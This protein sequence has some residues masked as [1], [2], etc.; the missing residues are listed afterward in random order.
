VISLQQVVEGFMVLY[1]TTAE[2]I[3]AIESALDGPGRRRLRRQLGEWTTKVV[4]VE[5]L[6]PDVYARW[7][8]LVHD[9]MLFVVSRLSS[10]R[11]APKVVEQ[12]EVPPDTPGE[13]RL[14]R[15]IA[16]V[17][18][19]QKIGQVLARNR[20][21][22]PP[23][24]AA[25]SELENGISDVRWPE[26]AEVILEEL[27]PRLGEYSVR[28]E[29]TIL[30]EASVSAVIPFTWRNPASGR[31]ERGVFKVLKPH[32]PGC[33]AEDMAIL[34]QLASKLA[35]KHRGEG[36]RLGGFSETL[37]DVRRLLEHEVDFIGEQRTLPEAGRTFGSIPGVRVPRVIAPLC[38]PIVTA[39]SREPGTKITNAR[40]VPNGERR[41]VAGRLVEAAMAVPT[42]SLKRNSLFHA[43]PHA[44]NLLYDKTRGEVVFLDW[45]LTERLSC[46]HRRYMA[47]LVA[48]MMLRDPGGVCAAIDGLRHRHGSTSSPQEMLIRERVLRFLDS[49]PP[50]YPAGPMDAMRLLDEIALEGIRFPAPLIMFRKAA[51]TL[52]GVMKDI[53]GSDVR[54]DATLERYAREHWLRTSAAMLWLLTARDWIGLGWSAL[55]LP[56]RL[57]ACRTLRF[58]DG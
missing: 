24:R 56:G 28:L 43:D 2:R 48:S 20:Q 40:A 36:V 22:D 13:Q 23:L 5:M 46:E 12:L 41:R 1:P 49:M 26:V 6:V 17:P 8:P 15:F 32:I 3:A 58:A 45:A 16:K 50:L 37:I 30:A 4:P 19:L 29:S 11:L 47:V 14:L 34:Q 42:L 33:F 27:G 7:R 39:L 35:R 55:C 51:F 21:L 53:A 54:I 25:L 44:G 38:T 18:G 31:R 10:K 57:L 52:D 9:A